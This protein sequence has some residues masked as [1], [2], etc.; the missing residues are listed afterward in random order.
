[1]I[2]MPPLIYKGLG[3]YP[4]KTWTPIIEKYGADITNNVHTHTKKFL[5]TCEMYF[6]IYIL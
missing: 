2:I 3:V 5:Y 4:M 6:A 1:M